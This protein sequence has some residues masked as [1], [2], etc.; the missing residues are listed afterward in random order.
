MGTV[1]GVI[2]VEMQAYDA[3]QQL[4]SQAQLRRY[5][6][7]VAVETV[8][9]QMHGDSSSEA[10]RRLAKY[11]GVFGTPENGGS[12]AIAMTAPVVNSGMPIAMTAPVTNA[13][14]KMAF[15][16]PARFQSV[17]DA[18]S[19]TN[20]LVSLR[21]I[22]SRVMA[23][24]TFSGSANEDSVH[25]RDRTRRTNF[26]YCDSVIACFWGEPCVVER[27]TGAFFG[28]RYWLMNRLGAW[29]V[30]PFVVAKVLNHQAVQNQINHVHRWI[31][32]EILAP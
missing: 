5:K 17:A 4:S 8:C 16:L 6:P 20:P 29:V 27:D 28:V 1:F 12:S 26:K 10:F 15:I 22:E 23:A 7:C 18:P 21:Q 32:T 13:D 19:P 30:E 11:I 3:L 25:R 14:G 9:E 24:L 31:F 2:S